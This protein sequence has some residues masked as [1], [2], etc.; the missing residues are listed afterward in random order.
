M[1]QILRQIQSIDS[2]QK[3]YGR[4]KIH[5]QFSESQIDNQA[6]HIVKQINTLGL[7]HDAL[8]TLDQ[9]QVTKKCI[10]LLK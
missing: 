1:D 7:K 9:S 3:R 10:E 6:K 5:S 8:E 4:L 2:M